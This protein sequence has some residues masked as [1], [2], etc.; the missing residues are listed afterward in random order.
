MCWIEE[1]TSLNIRGRNLNTESRYLD[2]RLEIHVCQTS[3]LSD[4]QL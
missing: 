4:R 2:H 3:F 1:S